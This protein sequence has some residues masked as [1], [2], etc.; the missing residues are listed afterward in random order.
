V[1][2]AP[3]A[4]DHEL[5]LGQ[6]ARSCP[7][8]ATPP[9][10]GRVS[11]AERVDDERLDR[12][13]F[14]ARKF[15]ELMHWRLVECATCGV[16]FASPAPSGDALAAAYADA[17]YDSFEEARFAARTYGELLDDKAA[18]LLPGTALDIGA[19]DGAFLGV[20]ADMG[21][22]VA[23]VEPSR[24]PIAAADARIRGA[25][26]ESIFR[27]GDF[28]PAGFRLVSCLQTIE[29]VP[30]PM[31]V[32]R[33]AYELLS[34]GGGVFVVCHDRKAPLNRLLGRRSPIYDVEHLQLFDRRSL[35]TLLTRAGFGEIEIR[36]FANQYPLRYWVRLLPLPRAVKVRAIAAL[37]RTR[38]GAVA[39][40]LPVG[41]LAA[42]A[43][44]PAD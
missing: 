8:C 26:R 30:E 5:R 6:A 4:T 11:H 17:G 19:G 35:R 25:I 36:R 38:L 9:D 43:F 41:N 13:A 7:V 24:A 39:V 44:K 16:L 20:L 2:D 1:V 28:E 37:D 42:T 18:R 14:A 3:G 27:P 29:H 34:G 31:V 40:T 32:L 33:G 15:P 23:G 12:F 22:E 10:A 21:F